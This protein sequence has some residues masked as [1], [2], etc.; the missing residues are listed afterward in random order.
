MRKFWSILFI[1]SMFCS[2]YLF[3]LPDRKVPELIASIGF[4]VW[5]AIC[6]YELLKRK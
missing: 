4:I 2:V 5:A 6:V 3:F 1:V